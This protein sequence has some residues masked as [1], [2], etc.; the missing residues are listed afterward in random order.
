MP[1]SVSVSCPYW[2]KRLKSQKQ[3]V[4]SVSNGK[5]CVA[6]LL[7]CLI[8][9]PSTGCGEPTSSVYGTVSY[10]GAEIQKGMITFS[11]ADGKGSSVGC[12]IKGGKYSASGLKPG[13]TIFNVVAVKDVTFARNSEDMASRA[14]SQNKNDPI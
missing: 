2:S 13:K 12:D 8:V 6:L 4:L 5:S 10:E 14:K 9:A 7:V 1:D 11:P 3:A